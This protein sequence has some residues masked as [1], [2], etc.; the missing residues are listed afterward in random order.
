MMHLKTQDA[1]HSRCLHGFL[2]ELGMLAS[3]ARRRQMLKAGMLAI[4]GHIQHH[5]CFW[6]HE[7]SLRMKTLF[8]DV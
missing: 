3:A 2:S 6:S 7:D 4:Q 5:G 1:H 8:P